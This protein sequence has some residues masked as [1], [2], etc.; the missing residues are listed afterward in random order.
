M[1]KSSRNTVFKKFAIFRR[2]SIEIPENSDHNIGPRYRAMSASLNSGE[3]SQEQ[4]SEAKF[5]RVKLLKLAEIVDATSK[6]IA[7]LEIDGE[8]VTS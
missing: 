6:K 2:K 4:L 8:Q 7:T 3:G 1:Q 5:L